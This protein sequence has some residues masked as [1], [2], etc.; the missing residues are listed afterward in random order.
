MV[1]QELDPALKTIANPVR[2]QILLLL[3]DPVKNFRPNDHGISN[4]EGVCVGSIADRVQLAQSTVS[5][6]LLKLQ[7]SGL[8]SFF[9]SG[10]WT[11]FRRNEKAVRT[12]LGKLRQ[13]L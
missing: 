1:S 4:T 3:K 10:K 5:A 2:R 6:H 12:L 7:E 8:V 11:Y 9:S 13:S